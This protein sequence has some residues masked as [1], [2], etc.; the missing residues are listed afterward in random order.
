MSVNFLWKQDFAEDDYLQKV[1]LR[2]LDAKGR[3]AGSHAH[4]AGTWAALAGP[5][6]HKGGMPEM[7][8]H[9]H[10]VGLQP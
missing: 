2:W 1:A 5:C 6:N 7:L 9:G 10:W 8:L 4:G 3:P